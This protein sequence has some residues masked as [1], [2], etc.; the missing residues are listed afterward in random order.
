MGSENAHG[1]AE[2]QRIVSVLPFLERYHK[3]GNGYFSHIIRVR[4]DET[5]ILF[6]NVETKKE[7]KQWMH[8]QSQN[9]PKTFNY[10][11]SAPQ[12]TGGSYIL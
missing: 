10:T 9:K 1:C 7:S 6:V 4:D 3:D 12:E 2:E 8:T 5:G 11:F